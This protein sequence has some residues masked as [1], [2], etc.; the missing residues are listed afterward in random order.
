VTKFFLV[1][2]LILFSLNFYSCSD[3]PSSVGLDQIKDLDFLKIDTLRSSDPGSLEQTSSYFKRVISL[4][5][6]TRLLIGKK[7][8]LAAHTLMNFIFLIPDSIKSDF[9]NNNITIDKAIIE[10]FPQYFYTDST[11]AFDFSAHRINSAWTSS[12]FSADSF[13]N[14]QYGADDIILSKNFEDS[15]YKFEI[16]NQVAR[17]WIDYSIAPD[18]LKNYGMLISPTLG[19][20]KVM[21][22]AGFDPFSE[23]ES[24]IKVIITKTGA[25]T[26]TLSGFVS[27]DV[28]VVLGNLP[29]ET[30]YI[31]VQSSL[32]INSKLFFDLTQ[33]P[34]HAVINDARLTLYT[35]STKNVF[36]STYNN[37]ISAFVVAAA[38]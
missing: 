8:D 38:E 11:A 30:E 33:I 25:Y 37:T 24:R 10:F 27:S 19:T 1:S 4:G 12:G 18:S 17:E 2:L 15:V 6:S 34:D 29:D 28:S 36:G 26:D 5:N 14:L 22:F 7:D 3:E 20:E 9:T 32:T 21:G 13:S 23:I 16:S 35:D 31:I